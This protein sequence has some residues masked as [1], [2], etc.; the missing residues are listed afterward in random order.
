METQNTQIF[1][2]DNLTS[3]VKK[4]GSDDR[5]YIVEGYAST[6]DKDLVSDIVSRNCLKAMLNQLKNRNVKLD[7]EH[8]AFV[9]DNKIDYE[10]NKTKEP[11][12]KIIDASIVD[13]RLMIKAELN[14]NWKQLDEKKNI[15]RD[16]KN[17]WESIENE[18]LDAFSI[19]YVPTDVKEMKDSRILDNLNLLNVAL[20]GNPVNP[21]ATMTKV[22]AKSLNLLDKK[23][24]EKMSEEDQK[25][26]DENLDKKSD[27]ETKSNENF[28]KLKKSF[29]EIKEELFEVKS[30][31]KNILEKDE[32]E[33]ESDE[34]KEE[35][36]SSDF[37][38]L[39]KSLDEIKK[40]NKE[41]KSTLE[42]TQK[43]GYGP[44]E[45]KSNEQKSDSETILS[46]IR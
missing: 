10:V 41:I 37:D 32:E 40:E 24:D 8:E 46:M 38:E 35:K 15:V 1:Y 29:E 3:I 13:D 16:F 19:A 18:F 11:L 26:K 17:V 21:N 6:T 20:T 45:K 23:G 27:D 28:D 7:F 36:K 2:S 9:G 44:Q 12:G 22:M 31:I 4:K 5:K 39:K 25:K 43:K 33:D 34:D 30:Q 42:K 14:K